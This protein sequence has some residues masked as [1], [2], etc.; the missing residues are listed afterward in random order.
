MIALYRV[1][2]IYMDVGSSVDITYVHCFNKLPKHIRSCL[3]PPTTSLIGFSRERSYHE[4]VVNL[5]LRV[6]SHP[7]SRTIMLRFHIIKSTSKYNV[8]LGRTTIQKLN[9]EVSTIRS[10]VEFPT[11]AGIAIVRSDYPGRDA[12]LAAAVEEGKI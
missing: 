3:R 10:V 6:G 5:T 8:I 12:S 4:G 2:R 7:L 1:S 11:K 9:M